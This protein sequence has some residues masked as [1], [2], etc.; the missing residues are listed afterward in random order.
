MLVAAEIF[1]GTPIGFIPTWLADAWRIA[2]WAS[3]SIVVI[4]M[5]A[6]AMRPE[7]VSPAVAYGRVA[8][9]VLIAAEFVLD[10]ERW[11]QPIT[12]EGLPP[13]TIAVVFAWLAMRGER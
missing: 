12:W 7:R 1:P 4:R 9:I 6:R 10:A 8:V 3:A 11:R 5:A 2:F 13:A